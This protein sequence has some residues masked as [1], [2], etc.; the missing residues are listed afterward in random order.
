MPSTASKSKVMTTMYAVKN[1]PDLANA[2]DA[3]AELQLV[4]QNLICLRPR[5]CDNVRAPI[6]R[7]RDKRGQT[8][9]NEDKRNRINYLRLAS[10]SFVWPRLS[11]DPLSWYPNF[12]ADSRP[13]GGPGKPG[14]ANRAGAFACTA[15]LTLLCCPPPYP[16]WT[17]PP[18]GRGRV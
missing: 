1:S 8:K 6:K 18:G 11:W 9:A 17:L 7:E 14:P 13:P 3:V 10:F 15:N 5:I 4:L 2:V 12:V 16:P